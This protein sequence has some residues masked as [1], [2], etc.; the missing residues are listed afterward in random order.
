MNKI[1]ILTYCLIC[2]SSFEHLYL[3]YSVQ[4]G[5]LE[6]TFNLQVNL[7]MLE[8]L[9]SFYFLNWVVKGQKLGKPRLE[10]MTEG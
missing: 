7:H 8:V 4:I 5:T 2:T 10:V 1:I 9:A 6:H 3:F